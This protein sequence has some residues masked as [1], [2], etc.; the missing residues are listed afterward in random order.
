M[1]L[2]NLEPKFLSKL[3]RIRGVP[4]LPTAA[5]AEYTGL[6]HW[7]LHRL[8][9]GKIVRRHS[10]NLR[11][12]FFPVTKLEALETV[13]PNLADRPDDSDL[14]FTEEACELVGCCGH[15]LRSIA[16]RSKGK[17]KPVPE[18]VRD[19]KGKKC[20]RPTW[21]KSEL[22]SL[23]V[24][25]PDPGQPII[26]TDGPG[27]ERRWYLRDHATANYACSNIV[28]AY[29]THRKSIRRPG[30]ALRTRPF[31]VIGKKSHR[32]KKLTAWN[33]DDLEA[34]ANG[35]EGKAPL[36]GRS[37]FAQRQQANLH[38]DI[39]RFFEEVKAQLPMLAAAGG[40]L[41]KKRG[42]KYG[43]V[44][45]HRKAAGIYVKRAPRPGSAPEYWWCRRNQ[46]PPT[47]SEPERDR[48]IQLD[49]TTTAMPSAAVRTHEASPPAPR[50]PAPEP[51]PVY[52]PGNSLESPLY[53]AHVGALVPNSTI[54]FDSRL[55]FDET[56][57]TIYLDR[58]PYKVSTPNAFA[59]YKHLAAQNGT[60]VTRQQIR[61]ADRRFRGDK[62]VV[63]LLNRLPSS[64]RH[65][66]KSGESGYWLHLPDVSVRPTP[67]LD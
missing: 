6:P 15:T 62:T 34:I 67:V 31:Y 43:L 48:G 46:E 42:F 17:L 61:V 8:K 60:P 32:Q 2:E 13:L 36:C 57:F 41:A 14:I 7:R 55:R 28:L 1:S 22:F 53:V 66:V 38:R 33:V 58:I 50:L 25:E 39:K 63:R 45:K 54:T 23:F 29:W 56:T 20:T 44:N 37:L 3:V 4:C 16:K 10:G 19:A 52:L 64:L 18:I 5:A 9:L 21:R 26:L 27:D 40:E 30:V 12:A 59:L 24:Y 51:Y 65:T 47:N 11:N 35:K 49:D